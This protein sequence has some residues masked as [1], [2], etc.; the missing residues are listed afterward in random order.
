MSLRLRAY[1]ITLS[2]TGVAQPLKDPAA[3]TIG[4]FIVNTFNTRCDKDNAEDMDMGDSTVTTGNGMFIEPGGGK[5]SDG[6]PVS[7]GK[8]T[9]WDLCQIYVVGTSGDSI[10]VE[11]SIYE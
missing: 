7:R 9:E 5:G 1:K 2:A 10:R 3:T 6:L 11:W 8:I 4:K